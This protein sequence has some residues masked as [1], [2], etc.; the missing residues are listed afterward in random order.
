MIPEDFWNQDDRHRD[1]KFYVGFCMLESALGDY[2][3]ARDLHCHNKLNWASTTYY[4]SL[5]HA[6]RLVCFI[7]LGD[8]PMG[9]TDLAKL[10]KDGA[11]CSEKRRERWLPRFRKDIVFENQILFNRDCIA[12]YY[13]SEQNYPTLN[14]KLERWGK[15]LD[16][17]RECRN[18]SNYE[19]LIIAHEHIHQVVTDDFNRLAI[20]F[21]K[22]C[23]EILP[24]IILLFKKFIDK[25]PR[26]DYWY[27]YLNWE[28]KIEGLSYF[29]DYLKFRLLGLSNVWVISE[30]SQDF[31]PTFDTRNNSAIVTEILR[32]LDTIRVNNIDNSFGEEV[33]NNIKLDIF[34]DKKSLMNSFRSQIDKL[35]G[36]VDGE[37]DDH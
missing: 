19:G 15:I 34:N 16:K 23:E 27:S 31:R 5:V 10:Y 3:I 22:T 36:I 24:E 12:R 4:Y 18:D 1:Q 25:N 28:N 21:L 9:H 29:E 20:I 2:A 32:W 30:S 6:L 7:P 37:A 11:F 13:V 8:L 26:K 33:W 35:E 17:A 14:N